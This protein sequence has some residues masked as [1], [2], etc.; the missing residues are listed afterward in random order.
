MGRTVGRII[1]LVIGFLA[2]GI[3][4]VQAS[5]T[6]LTKNSNSPV[7]MRYGVPP[8]PFTLD[9]K[10][11]EPETLPTFSGRV[12]HFAYDTRAQAEGIIRVFSSDQDIRAYIAESRES[13]TDVSTQAE[14]WRCAW[15][16]EHPNR[17]G[18]SIS[19]CG[20]DRWPGM[21]WWNNRISSLQTGGG[22]NV[23]VWTGGNYS[24]SSMWIGGSTTY[25]SLSW[26]NDSISS[27]E[28]DPQ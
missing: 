14:S 24:G 6:G 4:A 9:G 15:F 18:P 12:L 5:S 1:L 10:R 28:M 23:R 26:W 3:G 22:T 19:K 11:Y 8:L 2:A 16:Y 7:Y 17:T 13:N 20:S 25:D 21:G 27:L